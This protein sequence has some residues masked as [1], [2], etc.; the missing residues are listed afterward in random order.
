M[1]ER[2]RT[3][4]V[5]RDNPQIINAE[6]I[7]E[8]AYQMMG[9]PDH[10]T[11][12]RRGRIRNWNNEAGAMPVGYQEERDAVLGDTTVNDPPRGILSSGERRIVERLPVTGLAGDVT[13]MGKMVYASNGGI[14]YTLTRP[15]P[16]VP[17]GFVVQFLD[18]TI[19]DVW[20]FSREVL[21]AMMLAPAGQYVWQSAPFPLAA[22]GSKTSFA[23]PS[24]G[25]ILSV[26]AVVVATVGAGDTDVNVD[27]GGVNVTGGTVSLA[28][29]EAIGTRVAGTAVTA[30]NVF[31]EG[32][33]VTIET[34]E[35]VANTGEAI[36]ELLIATDVAAL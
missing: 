1:A 7:T 14:T 22:T 4:G 17:I 18:A 32:D 2:L 25:T 3:R 13:D 24:R 30:L 9:A 6:T 35:N 21:V 31:H 19:A 12:A 23:A 28:G 27:I 36:I 11:V 8:G 33:I 29:A 15:T 34:T 5:E 10:A 16:G 26:T 20:M